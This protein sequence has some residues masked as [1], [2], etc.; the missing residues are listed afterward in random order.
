MKPSLFYSQ[1]QVLKQQTPESPVWDLAA[2]GELCNSWAN[3]STRLSEP[4]FLI[5]KM[6]TTV[7]PN[8]IAVGIKRVSCKTSQPRTWRVGSFLDV[9]CCP[10]Y[11]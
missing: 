6:L 7:P 1:V 2:R 5:R 4:Y 3:H 10:S 8:K 11:F 9:G